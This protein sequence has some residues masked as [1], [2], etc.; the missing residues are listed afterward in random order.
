MALL[1]ADEEPVWVLERHTGEVLE[2]RID[3]DGYVREIDGSGAFA[4][5]PYVL[6]TGK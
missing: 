5:G 1:Q 2:A 3:E 6:L 4:E